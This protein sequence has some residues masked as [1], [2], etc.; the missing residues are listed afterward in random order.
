MNYITGFGRKHIF[1]AFMRGGT[2]TDNQVAL[3]MLHYNTKDMMF[4]SKKVNVFG[5]NFT[6]FSVFA[7]VTQHPGS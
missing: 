7:T 3:S 4:H 6:T 5:G 1:D 2:I